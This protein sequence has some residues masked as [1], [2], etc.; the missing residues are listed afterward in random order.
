[1]L[2]IVWF[3]CLCLSCFEF[4]DN[5]EFRKEKEEM[6]KSEDNSTWSGEDTPPILIMSQ[7]SNVQKLEPLLKPLSYKQDQ[8]KV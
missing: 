4:S 2:S 1:M 6:M 7:S 3:R 5:D 8:P